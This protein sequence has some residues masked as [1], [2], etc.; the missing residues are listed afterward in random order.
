MRTRLSTRLFQLHVPLLVTL[1]HDNRRFN[2][3]IEG[4]VKFKVCSIRQLTRINTSKFGENLFTNKV[5]NGEQFKFP[6]TL[7]VVY[8]SDSDYHF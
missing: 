7:F 3:Y 5:L 4:L 8:Y 2:R 6:T 1:G